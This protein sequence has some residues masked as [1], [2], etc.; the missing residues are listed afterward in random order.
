MA[1]LSIHEDRFSQYD[2]AAMATL[3]PAHIHVRVCADICWFGCTLHCLR[4]LSHSMFVDY[5]CFLCA[6]VVIDVFF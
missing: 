6:V 1:K 2:S 5:F 4:S 3:R